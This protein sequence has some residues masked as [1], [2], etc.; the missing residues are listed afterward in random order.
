MY[1]QQI[2]SSSS[3]LLGGTA[4]VDSPKREL[5]VEGVVN[6]LEFWAAEVGQSLDRL[7]SRLTPVLAPPMPTGVGSDTAGRSCILA[8]RIDSTVSRLI[9]FQN[10][11]REIE[12]RLEI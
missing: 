7:Y 2:K 6:S 8:G 10:L 12:D 3:A 1:G 5:E 9:G 11:L 4:Q